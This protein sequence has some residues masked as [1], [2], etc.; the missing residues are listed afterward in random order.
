MLGLGAACARTASLRAPAV[1]GRAAE[2]RVG[3]LLL[4]LLHAAA[5]RPLR[6][7]RPLLLLLSAIIVA[8]GGR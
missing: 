3:L 4:P 7:A 2:R 8:L 6:C 5:R 1:R